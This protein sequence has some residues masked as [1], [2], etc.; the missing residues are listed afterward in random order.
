M[1]ILELHEMIRVSHAVECPV[2]FMLFYDWDEQGGV[3][4]NVEND[5]F[6]VFYPPGSCFPCFWRV[7]G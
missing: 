6:L 1:I 7:S 2:I 5:L 4:K 3:F